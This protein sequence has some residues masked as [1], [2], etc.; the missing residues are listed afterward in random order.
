CPARQGIRSIRPRVASASSRRLPSPRPGSPFL[1]S[2][3]GATGADSTDACERCNRFHVPNVSLVQGGRPVLL[4][5]QLNKEIHDLPEPP[6]RRRCPRLGRSGGRRVRRRALREPGP[7]GGG[8]VP[9]QRL[10][11]PLRLAVLLRRL[12]GG[13]PAPAGPLLHRP[14]RLRPPSGGRGRP[15]GPRPRRR[16]RRPLLRDRAPRL[17]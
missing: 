13:D 9:D 2:P 5:P 12:V 8:A 15:R 4:E 6:A 7:R 14:R 17:L 10:G 1:P 16:P 11:P 3:T